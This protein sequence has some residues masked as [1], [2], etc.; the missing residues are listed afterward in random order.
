[1][2]TA[3]PTSL[4][5]YSTA[6]ST[7]SGTTSTEHFKT[8]TMTPL[9]TAT[10]QYDYEGSTTTL[11]DGREADSIATTL[12]F[13]R[14]QT[15]T[16]DSLLTTIVSIP[17]ET[18][19][20]TAA[21]TAVETTTLLTIDELT[22]LFPELPTTLSSTSTTSLDETTVSSS[23][24]VAGTET[25]STVTSETMT[26]IVTTP[27]DLLT[28]IAIGMP[29]PRPDDRS[30]NEEREVRTTTF[31]HGI[32]LTTSITAKQS[33]KLDEI[34]TT[35]AP[36]TYPTVDI[37]TVTQPTNR[38][39]IEDNMVTIT[40]E[41]EIATL[42]TTTSE[43]PSNKSGTTVLYPD[44]LPDFPDST[45]PSIMTDPDHTKPRQPE[46][47]T[48]KSV[49]STIPVNTCTYDLCMNGGTCVMT[50]EGWQV[51]KSAIPSIPVR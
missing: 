23:S 4:S 45:D 37:T 42:S 26:T 1:M 24:T 5:K 22:T 33:T 9:Y 28:T 19:I 29:E 8:T 13:E 17:E 6:K 43:I 25:S 14:E 47:T 49:E 40:L 38:Q 2:T 51:F 35:T 46:H 34:S 32:R 12:Y 27:S 44:D 15:T 30:G 16:F 21:T 11:F 50:S 20:S 48:I 39:P 3:S 10:D 41:P 36:S 18:T 31:S 7:T